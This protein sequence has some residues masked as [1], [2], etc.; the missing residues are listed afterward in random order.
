MATDT[1][2]DFSLWLFERCSPQ[3]T[4]EMLRSIGYV[5]AHNEHMQI[6]KKPFFQIKD[7]DE[8]QKIRFSIQGN[9]LFV[10][11]H[12]GKMPA[13]VDF[14]N[15]YVRYLRYQQ[16]Q[17][18]SSVQ[19]PV[20]EEPQNSEVERECITTADDRSYKNRFYEWMINEEKCSL[21]TARNY[22]RALRVL[23]EEGAAW[24]V[25]RQSIFSM[26]SLQIFDMET[27]KL[28]ED[29]RVIAM[30]KKHHN[31]YSAAL[32]KFRT[33]LVQT[34]NDGNLVVSSIVGQTALGSTATGE[35]AP[36]VQMAEPITKHLFAKKVDWSLFHYGFAIPQSHV[37]AFY[38]VI[39]VE[40]DSDRSK[41]K[42]DILFNG[43]W[44][45][46]R[47]II[48]GRSVQVRWRT[49]N[50]DIALDLRIAFKEVFEQLKE[51]R[52]RDTNGQ[53][54]KQDLYIDINTTTIRGQLAFAQS[55]APDPQKGIDPKDVVAWLVTQPNAYG[56]P[57]LENVAKQYMYSLRSSPLKLEIPLSLESRNVFA[58]QTAEELTALCESFNAAPN[59]KQVNRSTSGM[60]SAG[61]S[62]YLRYLLH[63]AATKKTA[64]HQ[65][66]T[67]QANSSGA[68]YINSDRAKAPESA[69]VTLSP[70]L[71]EQLEDVLSTRFSNGYRL[72]SPIEMARFR[73]FASEKLG[74]ELTLSDEE[75]KSYI[76]SC[77][78]IYEGKVFIV[79]T[80]TKER[81][82]RLA[83]EY[84][85]EGGQVIFFAEFYIRNENWLFEASVVSED[86][87]TDILRNLFPKLSFTQ[88]YFGCTDTSVPIVLES[89]ILRV[90]VDVLETYKRLTERLTYIPLDRIK[91]A[92]SQNGDFIWNS[93]ETFSHISRID[94]AEVEREA[95][96]AAAARECNTHGYVSVTDL[97]IDEIKERNYELSITAVHNA[98]YRVCLSG[99]FDKK[100]KIITRK[101]DIFDALTIMKEHCRTIDKCSLNDLLAFEKELM[102][103]IH[104]WI[105]MEA[106]NTVLVRID[107]E[108]YVADRYVR[109]NASLI[110]EAIG[111]VIDGDYCPLKS[112]TTFGAF[113]DCGQAWNLFLLESYCR[114]FSRE[115]RFEALSV[116]SR[117]AGAIIH[118]SCGMEYIEI[119]TDAVANAEIPLKN[120]TVGSFL[121]DSGYTGRRTNTNV[122][123]IIDKAKAIRERRG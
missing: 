101:G 30:N 114:R 103:E 105:P 34:S 100:G 50:D 112:F 22:D 55:G 27:A 96:H 17:D 3:K 82:K 120:T 39:G 12:K 90:W 99:K 9:R 60:F 54:S 59:Y 5:V 74:K 102:G 104:R 56:M 72:N 91:T 63:L 117:N 20:A 44:Y 65:A 7:P 121:F 62:C 26:R 45:Q 46:A 92:L 61:M 48:F 68:F 88:T 113:P 81:I 75:M 94:I 38:E 13:I 47:A 23:S 29:A 1:I 107:K 66:P 2:Q 43:K 69:K 77:G 25:L 87:L 31:V 58:C 10:L 32:S 70:S 14:L 76:T 108:T 24:G 98:V 123:E 115:Y 109:F 106:G 21:S 95:I 33:H 118:K 110:D 6:V 73:S 83:E 52:N 35:A 8:I 122:D 40:L 49:T 85:A 53:L 89:E 80:D 116:N 93:I 78:T 41:A 15:C 19:T 4:N 11:K 71:A 86:M 36:A 111:L 97:P 67:A 28:S 79:S 64:T 57:Y 51:S 84:F 42:V 119:M 37:P 16:H 18:N